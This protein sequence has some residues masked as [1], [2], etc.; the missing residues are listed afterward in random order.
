MNY[1]RTPLTKP[2]LH[3]IALIAMLVLA[4]ADA[5]A[6]GSKSFGD[7]EVHYSVFTSTFIKPEVA[8]SYNIVR[9]KDRALIN[10]A[11]RKREANGDTRAEA[12]AISGNSSDLIHTTPLQFREIREQG[13]IYYL[14]ELRFY[15]RE[16]RT[17]T[18]DIQPQS[19]AETFT[20]KFSKKLY[21]D[22]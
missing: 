5:R 13:A 14:A 15:D 11:V 21:F 18:L 4:V 19:S 8:G 1:S 10:I 6:D 7:Y 20:L 12:A 22:E 3:A 2:L 16:L 9:G 17:F